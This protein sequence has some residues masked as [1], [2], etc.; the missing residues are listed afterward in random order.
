MNYNKFNTVTL[1]MS[2]FDGRPVYFVIVA[3][4]Q[5]A[6]E[7]SL[8]YLCASVCACVCVSVCVCFCMI[9]QKEINLVP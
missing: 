2:I 4:L 8:E 3:F 9:T 1:T 6:M 7:Y 5:N